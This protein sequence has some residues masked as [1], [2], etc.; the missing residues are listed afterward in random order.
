MNGRTA[1]NIY[2]KRALDYLVFIGIVSRE[3][4]IPHLA[5][6]LEM[7]IL[8]SPVTVMNFL[9]E[10]SLACAWCLL[11]ENEENSSEQA[12]WESPFGRSLLF[13]IYTA[14]WLAACLLL[15]LCVFISHY[16]FS[17]H[18]GKWFALFKFFQA[19]FFSQV[20]NFN[21]FMV[22]CRTVLTLTLCW[23]VVSSF[24]HS[25]LLPTFSSMKF[26]ITTRGSMK[27]AL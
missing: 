21:Q 27:R 1:M 15:F 18:A 4:C 16:F 8:T 11:D 26:S 19:C 14:R 5:A 12:R 3:G 20:S 7:F 6:R 25:P 24:L 22:L 10:F 2:Y 23:T 13:L 17:L 9:K